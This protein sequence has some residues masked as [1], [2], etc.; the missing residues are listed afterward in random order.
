MVEEKKNNGT[1]ILIV[2][3]VLLVIGL[4]GFIVYDQFIANTEIEE[5]IDNDYDNGWEESEIEEE[6]PLEVGE[7]TPGG[8]NAE[9]LEYTNSG[10]TQVRGYATLEEIVYEE[11]G[12]TAS[13]GDRFTF[14]RFNVIESGNAELVNL[15]QFE[16]GCLEESQVTGMTGNDFNSFILSRTDSERIINSNRENPIVL[17]LTFPQ[18]TL[19]FGGDNCF[20]W[21]NV[22]RIP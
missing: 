5:A 12:M 3:L 7:F 13:A 19:G 11:D 1:K 18:V 20:V 17:E 10:W 2:I 22:T 4:G 14:V 15:G 9:S 6:I 8:I 21:A 16:L